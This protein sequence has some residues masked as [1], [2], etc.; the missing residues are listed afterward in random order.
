MRALPLKSSPL[1]DTFAGLVKA[2]PA[3]DGAA[4]LAL[5]LGLPL[6][7]RAAMWRRLREEIEAEREVAE[8]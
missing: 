8:S 2:T 1:P 6:H 7:K 5:F 4:R 3:L